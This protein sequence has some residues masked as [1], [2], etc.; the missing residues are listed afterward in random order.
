MYY[1]A[2]KKGNAKFVILMMFGLKE[3]EIAES[4]FD[5]VFED[6]F[7]S[8]NGQI[9]LKDAKKIS[10]TFEKYEKYISRGSGGGVEEEQKEFT[11]IAVMAIE[12]EI[13]MLH[14]DLASWL[15][16]IESLCNK[17]E[18]EQHD[19]DINPGFSLHS[20]LIE[21]QWNNGHPDE[22]NPFINTSLTDYWKNSDYVAKIPPSGDKDN[23]MMNIIW[24]KV[25]GITAMVNML[26]TTK[27]DD[28]DIPR[29]LFADEAQ[30]LSKE[31]PPVLA[32]LPYFCDHKEISDM[33]HLILVSETII[34]QIMEWRWDEF[35]KAIDL[36]KQDKYNIVIV[37]SHS[38]LNAAYYGM[39]QIM[40]N[41]CICLIVSATPLYQSSHD[42]CNLARLICLKAFMGKKAESLKKKKVRE[43]SKIWRDV[44]K[45]NNSNNDALTIF[46]TN[47]LK[48]TLIKYTDLLADK[49][50]ML[51]NELPSY[52]K[53]KIMMSRWSNSSSLKAHG[54]VDVTDAMMFVP[55]YWLTIAYPQSQ[56]GHLVFPDPSAMVMSNKKRTQQ[57]KIL[58]FHEF[59]MMNEFIMLVFIMHGIKILSLNSSMR[60]TAY[61][62][63]DNS[64]LNLMRASVVIPFISFSIIPS[65]HSL[66]QIPQDIDTIDVLMAQHSGTK[67]QQLHHFFKKPDFNVCQNRKAFQLLYNYD[68]PADAPAAADGESDNNNDDSHQESTIEE[69]SAKKHEM[70][71]KK[72]VKTKEADI[73]NESHYCH[74]VLKNVTEDGNKE[75]ASAAKKVEKTMQRG[76]MNEAEPLNTQSKPK[77][78]LKPIMKSVP[79][80]QNTAEYH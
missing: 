61:Q 11:V 14:E 42:L 2:V 30:K 51:L 1:V 34:E 43:L 9:N 53:I 62:Q 55:N 75:G 27:L 23:K 37:A 54:A 10:N 72:I 31:L 64:G 79:S 56:Y 22:F 60:L 38:T 29:I 25:V 45:S 35:N 36:S 13:V 58:I 16:S 12:E 19:I 70:T 66:T 15:Q 7:E 49:P 41:I 69:P 50:I 77:S 5:R 73:I 20:G 67:A 24:H 78:K 68:I 80:A 18:A 71:S 46:N 59:P 48:V 63:T 6:I 47:A 32:Q 40:K 28:N 52:E 57:I 33:L 44:T 76:S 39:N 21:L 26:W 4:I 74:K 8:G 17:E 3:A 65:S